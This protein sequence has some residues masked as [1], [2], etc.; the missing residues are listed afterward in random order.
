[1]SLPDERSMSLPAEHRVSLPIEHSVSLPAEHRATPGGKPR[2]RG[3]GVPFTGRP[4]RWNAITDV[5]GVE[6]GYITLVEGDNVRTGVTAIH[7]PRQRGHLRRLRLP[8]R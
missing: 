5:P 2:A 7:P 4:G 8:H 1:M 3:L 6:V